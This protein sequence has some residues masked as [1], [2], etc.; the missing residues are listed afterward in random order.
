MPYTRFLDP[1]GPG[2]PAWNAF[3]NALAAYRLSLPPR[4][5]TF[6]ESTR[7][8]ERANPLVST[9]L[10]VRANLSESTMHTARAK[11]CVSAM[12]TE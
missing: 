5:A 12:W 4:L 11:Q 8:E 1:L 6:G 2:T 3:D 9:S 7:I 10:G